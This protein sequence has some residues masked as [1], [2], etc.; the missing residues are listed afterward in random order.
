MTIGVDLDGVLRDF[1]GGVKRLYRQEFPDRRICETRDYDLSL[2]FPDETNE[3]LWKWIIERAIILQEFI[4]PYDGAEE[5]LDEIRMLGHRVVLI[6]SQPQPRLQASVFVW[7]ARH[8]RLLR[9][10][11]TII[12]SDF[13]HRGKD[14]IP[15]DYLL[16]DSPDNLKRVRRK[17]TRPVLMKRPWSNG[18]QGESVT[19]YIEFINLLV[20]NHEMD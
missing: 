1:V 16:D 19:S 6:T 5:F 9:N 8:Q 10:I 14:C 20:T 15:L 11:D 2:S 4:E 18:W 7:L 17:R 12:V 13:R 3:T